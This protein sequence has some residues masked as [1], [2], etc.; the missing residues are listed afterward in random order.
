MSAFFNCQRTRGRERGGGGGGGAGGRERQTDRQTERANET[1][2][3][4]E[5]VADRERDRERRGGGRERFFIFISYLLTDSVH[6]F[7][8]VWS[9]LFFFIVIVIR[10]ISLICLSD[11]VH[12]AANSSTR[13][14][15]ICHT[16]SVSG[17][18]KLVFHRKLG[19]AEDME[20]QF[21]SAADSGGMAKFIDIV[22]L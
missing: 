15:D 12:S 11:S 5:G 1:E 2:S 8:L 14:I 22:P 20:H 16:A 19:S 10:P 6:G 13:S 9:E 18:M 4:R 7:P 17:T 21:Q 3:N